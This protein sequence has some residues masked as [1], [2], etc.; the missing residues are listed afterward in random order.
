MAIWQSLKVR[1]KL[2]FAMTF[3]GWL[4]PSP[5]TTTRKNNQTKPKQDHTHESQM[6]S[7]ANSSDYIITT[8]YS[9]HKNALP[10]TNDVNQNVIKKIFNGKNKF[11]YWKMVTTVD[12]TC[13]PVGGQLKPLKTISTGFEIFRPLLLLLKGCFL[14]TEAIG[15]SGTGAQDSH[16]DFHTAPEDLICL[17]TYFVHSWKILA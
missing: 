9:W 6:Q 17:G 11:F 13:H 12:S 8:V 5:P 1:I 15:L 10:R 2:S 16:L 14:S 7:K 3:Y 4:L